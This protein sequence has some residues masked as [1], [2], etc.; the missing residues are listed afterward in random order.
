MS[1]PSSGS[2]P[3]FAQEG[4]E[5]GQS[6]WGSPQGQPP[7]GQ[8]G[9]GPPQGQP[10][11]YGPA[12]SYSGPPAGYGA[13]GTGNRPGMVTAAGVVGI[14]WGALALLFGLLALGLAF[15]ISG[16]L[17]VIVLVAVI[18][19]VGL[20]V[21]GIYVITGRSPKILLYISYA[22]IA[23]NVIELIISLAQNGGNAFSGILGFVLPGV[24]VALLLQPQS[25]QY[26]AARGH[27][28]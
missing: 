1:T 19:G 22:A 14:V 10:P 25:K 8:P 7:G 20:L 13:G 6:G 24:I 16:L 23:I 27:S 12:P 9:W 21:G 28:Y 11:G 4:P 17:G 26:F 18:V 3:N 2:E 5:G 15:T